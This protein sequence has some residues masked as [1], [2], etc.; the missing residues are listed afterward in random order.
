M[1]AE[2]SLA[3]VFVFAITLASGW[4]RS[5]IR[6]AV[7]NLSTVSQRA[8][9]EAPD[10]APPKDPQTDELA[11]YAGLHRR[12]GWIVKGVWALGLVWMGY[13]LWLVAGVA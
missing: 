2:W 12:T 13:V 11:V 6:R 4:R 1:S 10:Y 9:G 8:L 7:R 5:K 3:M